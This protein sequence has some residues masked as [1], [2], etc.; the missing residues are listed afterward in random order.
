MLHYFHEVDFFS[1]LFNK[2]AKETNFNQKMISALK[3]EVGGAPLP[4]REMVSIR[5]IQRYLAKDDPND[6]RLFEPH[7]NPEVVH[8][9]KAE[10]DMA[11]LGERFPELDLEFFRDLD[12]VGD[13]FESKELKKEV[14][15]SFDLIDNIIYKIKRY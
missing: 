9:L 4:D 8:W 12:F 13:F 7:I 10:E 1:K 15:V 14:L 3:G 5:I 2:Y 6:P 11:V